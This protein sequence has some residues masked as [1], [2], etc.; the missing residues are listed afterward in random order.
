M[1]QEAMV[2]VIVEMERYDELIA[3][4]HAYEAIKHALEEN[5]PFFIDIARALCFVK[6]AE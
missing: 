3:K 5:Y 4:E 1:K 2:S 6:G